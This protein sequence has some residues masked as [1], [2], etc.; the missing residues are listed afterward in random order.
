MLKHL[1]KLSL[2][3]IRVKAAVQPGRHGTGEKYAAPLRHHR[4]VVLEAMNAKLASQLKSADLTYD[5]VGA[6]QGSLPCGYHHLRRSR[7]LGSG[8]DAF[9][10]A[11]SALLAWQV[12][13]RAGLRVTASEAVAEPG[14]VV[15]LSAGARP[16][17]LRAPC[18]VVYTVAE[19]Q[20][21]GF[22]YG[23]LPGH[24]ERGEEAFVVEQRD[25]GNIVFTITAFS[26]PATVSARAAGP[27]GRVIQ[28]YVTRRYLDALAELRNS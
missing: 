19:V 12:Q 21:R 16:L 2:L 17:Q 20:R 9:A 26:R 4:G 28:R 18:R 3:P 25:D 11:A 15:L 13:P 22:A 5:H 27:L 6:T 14:A 1:P 8:A 10:A 23:T 24:P 7:V